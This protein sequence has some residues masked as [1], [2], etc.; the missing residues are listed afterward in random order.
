MKKILLSAVLLSVIV[1]CKKST[2]GNT[3]IVKNTEESIVTNENGRI[4]S[5][6]AE[7]TTTEINGKTEKEETRSY[8]ASNGNRANIVLFSSAKENT[9]TIRANGQKYQLD[10]KSSTE[11]E[12]NGVKAEIKGDSLFII[13][14]DNVISL[15]RDL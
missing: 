4:D 14:G 6:S 5:A 9:M 11:Y 15:V 8:K 12:R 7:S 2:D 1:A 10:K 13:Q 3:G